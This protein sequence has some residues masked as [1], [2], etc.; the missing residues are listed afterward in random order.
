MTLYHFENT[1][2]VIEVNVTETGVKEQ[3]GRI[4]SFEFDATI[5]HSRKVVYHYWS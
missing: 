2:G 4:V 5:Q 3:F 1:L